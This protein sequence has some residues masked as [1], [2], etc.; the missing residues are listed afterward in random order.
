MEIYGRNE[1]TTER[2]NPAVPKDRENQSWDAL[3][4]PGRKKG[5]LPGVSLQPLKA[6]GKGETDLQEHPGAADRHSV[7]IVGLF[8]DIKGLS[9]SWGEGTNSS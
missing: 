1:M 3:G 8:L 5:L 2:A 7:K 6:S 9:K 4:R